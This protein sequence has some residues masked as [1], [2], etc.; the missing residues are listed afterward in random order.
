MSLILPST[1]RSLDCPLNR[2][3]T[4]KF[5]RG[6]IPLQIPLSV[7]HPTSVLGRGNC[8]GRVSLKIGSHMAETC[9]GAMTEAW[10]GL[11]VG[12]SPPVA[13][14]RTSGCPQRANLNQEFTGP[15]DQARQ[16]LACPSHF[17]ADKQDKNR[18]IYLTDT[19]KTVIDKQRENNGGYSLKLTSSTFL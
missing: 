6:F 15:S 17:F 19:A 10:H 18:Q 2:R 14:C 3:I 7:D 4:S 16:G 13:P 8:F 11:V 5:R 9:C 12:V 1:C